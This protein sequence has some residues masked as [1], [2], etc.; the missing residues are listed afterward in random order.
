MLGISPNFYKE[1]KRFRQKVIEE[2][3]REINNSGIGLAIKSE[4]VKQGRNLVAIR[5]YCTKTPRRLPVKGKGKQQVAPQ[6]EL[7]ELSPKTAKL[8]G[9]KE[10][11]H[12]QERYPE[13]FSALY[14]EELERP[15]FLPPTSETRKQA[16][17][18]A[19]QARLQRGTGLV[20]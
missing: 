17:Q 19:A 12:L 10:M 4:G 2:P 6:P 11:E 18:G 8:R 20:R 5:L 9:E 14:A 1:T 16:A 13:E 15:S 7:P 3:V